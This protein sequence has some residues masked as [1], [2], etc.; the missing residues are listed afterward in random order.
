MPS[1][2]PRG[3]PPGGRL[4]KAARKS[5]RSKCCEGTGWG[6]RKSRLGKDHMEV[7]FEPRSARRSS[8][9]GET[10]GAGV[11][12]EEARRAEVPGAGETLASR[13]HREATGVGTE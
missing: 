11:R 4:E 1:T 7:T 9:L 10:R 13:S 2:A 3:F 12:A 8:C 5:G 6:V